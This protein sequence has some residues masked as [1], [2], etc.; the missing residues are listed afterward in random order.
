MPRIRNEVSD[1]AGRKQRGQTVGAKL[2]HFDK[3]IQ[4]PAPKN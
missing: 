3:L 1:A 2:K 4:H